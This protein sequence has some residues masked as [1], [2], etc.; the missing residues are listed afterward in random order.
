MSRVLG[1][2]LIVSASFLVAAF[3]VA[4]IYVAVSNHSKGLV[5][6]SKVAGVHARRFP[7]KWLY[8]IA[9]VGLS[10][11]LVN[12]LMI[13]GTYSLGDVHVTQRQDDF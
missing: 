11:V 3:I 9:T 8:G 12:I 1:E 2:T 4:V 13:N 6:G 10:V 7:W 5:S